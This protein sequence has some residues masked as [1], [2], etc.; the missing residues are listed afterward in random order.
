MITG[1]SDTGKP[2]P[3]DATEEPAS[4]GSDTEPTTSGEPGTS[5]ETDQP[6][7]SGENTKIGKRLNLGLDLE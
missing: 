5:A 3:S 2:G 7:T 1:D 6:S 4:T